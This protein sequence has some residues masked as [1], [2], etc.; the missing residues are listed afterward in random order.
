ML[1]TQVTK[2]TEARYVSELEEVLAETLN[3]ESV[4]AIDIE[5]H[6]E[7]LAHHRQF[8]GHETS[9]LDPSDVIDILNE[10]YGKLC[11]LAYHKEGGVT[12]TCAH[13][14]QKWGALLEVCREKLDADDSHGWTALGASVQM[15]F[16]PFT[17]KES[18][19]QF[20]D[21][22]YTKALGLADNT[23]AIVQLAANHFSQEHYRNNALM[24]AAATKAFSL[25]ESFYDYRYFCFAGTE[26][27][28]F[29][30]TPY[31]QQAA[32]KATQ[33][34]LTAEHM[35]PQLVA[36]FEDH[37]VDVDA[38]IK[39]SLES[40]DTTRTYTFRREETIT[41][42]R[43]YELKLSGEMARLYQEDEDAFWERFE[44]EEMA[45]EWDLVN[46]RVGDPDTIHK[47]RL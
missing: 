47:L 18:T 33:L 40:F 13:Y 29:E 11:Y 2:I 25:A 24:D 20:A 34:R 7:D 21:E 14:E 26:V 15:K 31:F 12:E 46:E 38:L 23:M 32:V 19:Q 45:D 4:S 43:Y 42:V 1:D 44:D 16:T 41:D 36:L 6:L 3:R 37:D 28:L 27:A 10:K 17:D 30:D 22:A 8:L 9:A 35:W 5:S 39:T